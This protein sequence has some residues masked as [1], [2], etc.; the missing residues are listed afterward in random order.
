MF[1]EKECEW[2]RR[3]IECILPNWSLPDDIQL[4]PEDVAMGPAHLWS[5]IDPEKLEGSAQDLRT[6][7][8][9]DTA[10][11]PRSTTPR[12]SVL[13]GNS[14]MSSEPASNKQMYCMMQSQELSAYVRQHLEAYN[15]AQ[16]L[17]WL[18]LTLFD[19]AV[20]HILRA[21]RVFGVDD[22]HAILFGPDDVGRRSGTRLAAYMMG[23][24]FKEI[25]VTSGY[26]FKEWRVDIK[27]AMRQAGIDSIPTV[28]MLTEP[29]LLSFMDDINAILTVNSMLAIFSADELLQVS[30]RILFPFQQ[31]H[32]AKVRPSSTE[33]MEFFVSR[34]RKHLHIVLV[35]TASTTGHSTTLIKCARLNPGIIRSSLFDW[36]TPW[37]DPAFELVKN[38]WLCNW[39]TDNAVNRFVQ[40]CSHHQM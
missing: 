13:S 4:F 38:P 36:F 18:P 37:P 23:C 10:I 14:V 34:L 24:M 26:G 31:T 27:T 21:C 6:S 20:V 40:R 28:V 25:A 33:L 3:E 15:E 12:N 9:I 8:I 22:G 17:E 19:T 5:M 29:Q 35:V 2:F 16:A 1:C 32:P 39:L 11:S 7:T 30:E